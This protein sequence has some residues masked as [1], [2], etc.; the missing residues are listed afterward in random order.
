M[1]AR[2]RHGYTNY[3]VAF[4]SALSRAQQTLA[5]ILKEIN[6]EGVEQ[7]QVRFHRHSDKSSLMTCITNRT[8]P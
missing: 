3:D 5:I 4:T 7:H 1:R 2:D 6:E 8:K